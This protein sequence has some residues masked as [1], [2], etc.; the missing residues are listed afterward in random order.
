M[1]GRRAKSLTTNT[2]ASA[3]QVESEHQPEHS[4]PGLVLAWSSDGVES[5]DRAPL[6]EPLTVGRSSSVRWCIRDARLSR[7]HVEIGPSSSSSKAGKNSPTFIVRD[8]ESKN[9]TFVNGH[10]VSKERVV[11][12][13]SILR[14]GECLFVVVEDLRSLDAPGMTVQEE[15]PSIMASTFH[16]AGLLTALQVAARARPVIILAGEPGTGRAEAA[17]YLHHQTHEDAEKSPLVHLDALRMT[18]DDQA[19]TALFGESDEILGLGTGG[20][21]AEAM[22]GT[23]VIHDADYLPPRAQRS[24]LRV[25]TG[26]AE[27]THDERNLSVVLTR[28][29]SGPSESVKLVPEVQSRASLVN[30]APLNG[31]PEDIPSLFLAAL[32]RNL[33][34]NR[35]EAIVAALNAAQ[36]EQICLADASCVNQA[37]LSDLASTIAAYLEAEL[38]PE[39]ALERGFT[40]VLPGNDVTPTPTPSPRPRER[41]CASSD[42]GGRTHL[43]PEAWNLTTREHEIA[44]LAAEGLMT[45]NIAARLGIAETTVNAHLRKI[46][47]KAK[48]SG[49]RE[50]MVQVLRH[51]T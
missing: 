14:A 10:R 19:I 30:L 34:S 35:V 45:V 5:D 26:G 46:Y 48:I 23:L 2:T 18:R 21:V 4:I 11:G 15:A 33:D 25:V 49:R 3:L 16:G 31:H 38:E 8:L 39:R 42:G 9:G 37:L 36:M 44:L 22:G 24:L 51:D 41:S 32:R 43:F 28:T 47:R 6:S 17:R 12:P 1:D 20:A 50:L 40:E 27:K 13:G 29:T 7:Q